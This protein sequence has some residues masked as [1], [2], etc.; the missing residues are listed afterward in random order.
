MEKIK[1]QKLFNNAKQNYKELRKNQ[2]EIA[3]DTQK[4]CLRFIKK[5]K[6]VFISTPVLLG[7]YSHLF[8][9]HLSNLLL[10]KN[11]SS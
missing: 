2:N 11:Q 3:H 1:P 10:E 8:Q 4:I 6:A 5:K 7:C 9:S